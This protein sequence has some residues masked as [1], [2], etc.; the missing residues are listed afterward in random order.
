[1]ASNNVCFELTDSQ[2]YKL[3]GL[4]MK[5]KKEASGEAKGLILAQ[6]WV[7]GDGLAVAANFVSSENALKILSIVGE[8]PR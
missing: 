8:D 2:A 3:R 4:V 7:V 6:I 5:L 1:M